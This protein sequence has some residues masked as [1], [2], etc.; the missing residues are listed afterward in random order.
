QLSVDFEGNRNIIAAA[1]TAG[2]PR[3]VLV[4]TVGAGDSVEAQPWYIKP[5][6]KDFVAEKT[7]AEKYLQ[8]SGLEYTIVRP[9]WL[10]DRP[11]SGKA[12]L[13]NDHTQFSWIS[14][15][16]LGKLIAD[17]LRNDANVNKV[18][19]AFDSSI[20]RVWQVLF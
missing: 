11:P 10:L 1:K 8:A 12:A 2:I 7:K 17:T 3:V 6:L 16:E 18:L 15:T 20:D 19:T 9:G 4:S 5:F 13:T 14:R